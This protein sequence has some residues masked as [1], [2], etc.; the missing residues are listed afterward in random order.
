MAEALPSREMQRVGVQQYLS[1]D[2]LSLWP[3]SFWSST[4]NQ[5][6]PW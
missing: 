3:I 4:S 5:F 6:E 2:L 1:V